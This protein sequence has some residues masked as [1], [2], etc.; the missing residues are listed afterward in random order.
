MFSFAMNKFENRYLS[1]A[2]NLSEL[3][4]MK[5]KFTIESILPNDSLYCFYW[6][7]VKSVTFLP[8]LTND[9]EEHAYFS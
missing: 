4:S 8:E 3:V 6:T 5:D 7:L 2:S 9:Q 1:G